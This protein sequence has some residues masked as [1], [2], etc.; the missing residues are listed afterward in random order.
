MSNN[1]FLFSLLFIGFALFANPAFSLLFAQQPIND[2]IKTHQLDEVEVLGNKQRISRSVLPIQYYSQKEFLKSNAINIADVANNFSGVTLKDYGGIGGMKTVSVRGMD[3]H[4]TSV[5][6]DGVM[7]SNIQSGQID[8][9]A[10]PIDNIAELSLT[11]AQP[12]DFLQSARLFSNANVLNVE[13]LLPADKLGNKLGGKAYL[14]TGSFGFVNPGLVLL[15]NLGEKYKLSFSTDFITANGQYSFIQNYGVSQKD[16][17]AVLKRQNTDVHSL[18][19]ELNVG[20]SPSDKEQMLF[21]T[22]LFLSERGLPGS[23]TF[24]NDETSRERLKDKSLFTQ[25]KYKNRKSLKFQYNL[26]ARHHYSQSFYTDKDKKYAQTNGLLSHQYTQNEYYAS[27]S[28]ASN[29]L[30]NLIVSAAADGWVN[31]LNMV[32]NIDFKD[33]SRPKRYTTMANVAFKYFTNRFIV[34]ANVLHTAT[35]ETVEKG[36]AAQN[37]KKFS[38][39]VN[40]SF[41]LWEDKEYRIRTFYKNL[42]RLPTFNELYYQDLGNVNLLPENANLINVGFTGSEENVFNLFDVTFTVDAYHNK[43]ENKIVMLPKNGFFWSM[44]NRG[45]VNIL[46]ADAG[47]KTTFKLAKEQELAVRANYSFQNAEDVTPN[48]DNYGEQIPYMPLHSGSASVTY[49]QPNWEAGYNLLVSG[50][51]WIGQMT[52]KR[53]KMNPY[54]IHSIFLQIHRKNWHLKTEVINLLNSQYEVVKF[55]PMPRRNYRASLI[56]NF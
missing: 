30:D 43:V 2:T 9:G 46:G 41:Q 3:A 5:S 53:N 49:T 4:Y 19:S 40:A 12:T 44:L 42:Y 39:T 8:L 47:I 32:S 51:R 27:F 1:K 45:K 38:P 24:Y 7:L 26:V 52:E 54:A 29:L 15:K 20:F 36:T 14:K 25:I 23:I 31:N 16:S 21:K 22:N 56:Y 48:T 13:S 55:Y 50:T 28:V 34:G 37:R 17:A 33:F 10:F 6:Y 35:F 18:R 11:N